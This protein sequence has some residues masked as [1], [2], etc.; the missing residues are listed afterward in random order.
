M[1]L[2]KINYLDLANVR[3][4][5]GKSWNVIF[6]ALKLAFEDRK[7]NPKAWKFMVSLIYS[8]EPTMGGLIARY[9]KRILQCE[10]N[11]FKFYNIFFRR[12]ESIE[13]FEPYCYDSEGKIKARWSGTKEYSYMKPGRVFRALLIDMCFDINLGSSF[14]NHICENL[15]NAYKSSFKGE[16]YTLTVGYDF[17]DIYDSDA[18]VGD[19]HSCMNDCGYHTFYESCVDARSAYI[20]DRNGGMVARCVIYNKVR[21]EEGNVYRLAERQYSTD[22]N[23]I[24][25]MVLINKL[26][27][28][29]EIDGYKIVGASYD[30]RRNFVLND[31]TSL[32][33]RKL[34][35]RCDLEYEN[36]Y[37]SFQDSFAYYKDG[38]A[39][40]FPVSNAVSLDV[41]SGEVELEYDSVNGRYCASTRV[42]YI[43]DDYREEYNEETCDVREIDDYYYINGDYYDEVEVDI[44]GN[45]CRKDEVVYSEYHDGYIREDLAEWNDDMDDYIISGSDDF[46]IWMKDNDYVLVDGKLVDIDKTEEVYSMRNGT[47]KLIVLKGTCEYTFI[48]N[49]KVLKEDYENFKAFVEKFGI[50]ELKRIIDMVDAAA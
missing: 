34:R 44:D 41:T 9:N 47:R 8:P 6:S 4:S 40:N 20:S 26:I 50:E 35:I 22:Q 45:D 32:S 5:Y 24:L 23:P 31:G 7:N 3:K 2:F 15:S 37:V 33:D 17:A 48:E 14:L 49:Y 16:E 25:K 13:I 38:T 11:Y 42:V 27:E 39:Y 21:D 29:G 30:D 36:D 43:W 19:F 46:E 18:Q 28:A 1:L 12:P 10:G